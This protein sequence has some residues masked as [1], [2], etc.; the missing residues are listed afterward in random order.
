M[1][2]SDIEDMIKACPLL[3]RVND[4]REYFVEKAEFISVAD[5]TTSILYTHEGRKRHAIVSNINI[6]SIE[7]LGQHS[8][9]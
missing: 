5:Y 4:G 8:R 1:E 7:P 2:N 6:T 9:I 3:I